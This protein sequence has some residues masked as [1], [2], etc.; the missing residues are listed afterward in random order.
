M[1]HLKKLIYCILTI[2]IVF[3]CASCGEKHK[4][5]YKE[6]ITQPTCT[7]RGYS[8]FTCECGKSYVDK[9]VEKTAHNYRE[10]I[11]TTASCTQSGTKKYTCSNCGDYY[12]KSYSLREY[13]M[14]DIDQYADKSVGAITT[15]DKNGNI[16]LKEIGFVYSSDGKI[17]T[18]YYVIDGAFSAKIYINGTTYN[19]QSV[20]AY[21][22]TIGLIVLKTNATG[23]TPLK[24]CN[25]N[26]SVGSTVYTVGN[27][28][29]L[30]WSE[31]KINTADAVISGVHYVQYDAPVSIGYSGAPLLNRYGEV[32][33]INTVYT[34]YS[35]SLNFAIST[36]E[37][38]NLKYGTS[39]TLAELYEKEGDVF[40]KIK[41]YIIKKG[42]YD[43]EDNRYEIDFGSALV[44]SL[45]VTTKASYTVSRQEIDF[46]IFIQDTS[47]TSLNTTL[48]G[49]TVDKIDG[50]YTWAYLDNTDHVMY[51]QINAATWTSNSLLGY[52]GYSGISSAT[53]LSSIRK[54]ASSMV[55]ILLST[56]PYD[57]KEIS[58]T[59]KDLGFTSFEI[60]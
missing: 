12:T 38:S 34:K 51:G 7:Q 2:L 28:Q 37:I 55:N 21:D 48:L 19:I 23:L 29:G 8:T 36:K 59:P 30:T 25:N 20:L 42:T 18:N 11:T 39:L 60:K 10:S 27:E 6:T 16:L 13:S 22:K 14:Y 1:R 32:I 54:L 24:I 45:Y 17:I 5:I 44:E 31:G 46:K 57:F 52:T 56:I 50:T 47:T 43:R 53:L 41:N 49:I 15:Y 3:V 33:G 26:H 4:H 58:L 9:Y 35:A 40:T